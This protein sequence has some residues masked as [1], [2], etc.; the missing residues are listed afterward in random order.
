MMWKS[1]WMDI[2]VIIIAELKGRMDKGK[3]NDVEMKW[4][5]QKLAL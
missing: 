2:E 4:W 3:H 5:M 1:R